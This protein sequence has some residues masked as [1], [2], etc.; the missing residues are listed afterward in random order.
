MT[1][2]AFTGIWYVDIFSKSGEIAS[3]QVGRKQYYFF[4]KKTCYSHTD[5]IYFK[6]FI[7][8]VYAM[9]FDTLLKFVIPTKFYRPFAISS[10]FLFTSLFAKPYAIFRLTKYR[11]ASILLTIVFTEI[12]PSNKYEEENIGRN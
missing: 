9:L 5:L 1:I 12:Y 10:T 3:K 2:S 7:N 6:N 11:V 4:L 8:A